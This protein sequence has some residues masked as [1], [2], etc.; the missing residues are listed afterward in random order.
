[1]S[2][3]PETPEGLT[4]LKDQQADAGGAAHDVRGVLGVAGEGAVVAEV[5]V[6]DQ[7]GAVAAVRVPHKLQPVPER[8]LVVNVGGTA[9]VVE[10]LEDRRSV[11]IATCIFTFSSNWWMHHLSVVVLLRRSLCV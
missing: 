10:D 8:A 6:L 1:M 3:H 11:T 4:F 9:G 5:Q 7:D 2:F